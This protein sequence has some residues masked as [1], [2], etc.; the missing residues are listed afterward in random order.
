[1]FTPV[2]HSV[3]PWNYDLSTSYSRESQFHGALSASIHSRYRLLS[4]SLITPSRWTIERMSFTPHSV[5]PWNYDLSMDYIGDYRED[6]SFTPLPHSIEPWNYDL[7]MD[8]IGDYREDVLFTPLPHS[9]EC[10][11]MTLNQISCEMS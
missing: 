9:I 1:M 3:E 10:A 4:M 2:P 6:V 8:Y 5:E 7:S 11:T